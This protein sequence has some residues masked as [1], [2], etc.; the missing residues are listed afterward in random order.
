M[1]LNVDIVKVIGN[2][3]FCFTKGSKYMNGQEL[4][5]CPYCAEEI[6]AE[7]IKCR[8]CGSNLQKSKISE[9][10]YRIQE[11]KMIW[12][13]CTGLADIFGVSVTLMRIAFVIAAFFGWGII[14][15]IVLRFIMP[16][17]E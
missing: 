13:I 17:R 1:Q 8:H 15:Y 16:S 2:E 3:I 4:K 10:W 5:V 11:G 12:G 14:L 6:K 9:P 7:A